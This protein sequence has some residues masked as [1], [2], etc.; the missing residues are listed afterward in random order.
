ME[1]FFPYRLAVAAAGLSRQ[2]EDV[3][4]RDHGLSREEWRVLFLLADVTSLTSKELSVR[5]SLDKVQISR[6]A[7]RLEKKSLIEG[8]E[9]KDDRRLRDYACTEKG[10]AFFRTVFPQVEARANAVLSLLS[11]VELKALKDGLAALESATKA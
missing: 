1:N 2:L 7:R 9:S 5:S 11:P 8:Q 10:R 4:R 6:A 3:Y